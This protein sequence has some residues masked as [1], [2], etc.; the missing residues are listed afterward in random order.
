MIETDYELN[1]KGYMKRAVL[2]SV[3]LGAMP[4]LSMAQDDLYFTPSKAEQSAYQQKRTEE[5]RPVYYSGI[6]KSSDEYNRRGQYSYK[7]IGVDSLGNDIF[8]SRISTLHGDSVVLD[9]VYGGFT[10]SYQRGDDDFVYSRRMSRFD[11]FW[12]G[13]YDPWFAGRPSVYI[14]WGWH[15]PY[16]G[17]WYDPWDDPWYY[18]Y[19]G[20]YPYY[21]YY[22]GYPYYGYYG[23]YPYY[24]GYPYYYGYA[25][26]GWYGP[27]RGYYGWGYPYYGYRRGG[28]YTYNGH[29]GTANHWGRNSGNVY[30]G[31][32]ERGGAYGNFS[33]YRGQTGTMSPGQGGRF[34]GSSVPDRSN[35]GQFGG[36]RQTYGNQ[37]T[38][39][40]STPNSSYSAPSNSSFGGA[41][42]STFGG[43]SF[44]GSRA[45]GGSFG[46]SRGGG[47]SFGGHR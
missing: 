23:G 41:T 21:G 43:G 14:G 46:G 40:Y 19:Y 28:Y 47:G 45:G 1:N 8:M 5:D 29:T 31:S 34:N 33:G 24:R 13:Y 10:R 3:L 6:G 32:V 16:Y 12:G 9:T 39:S 44:G 2:L 25:G 35:V 11:G 18:G 26:Y 36:S 15:S 17:G 7:K 4:L 20:G 30:R 38:R 27:W 37:G 22:G 42:R